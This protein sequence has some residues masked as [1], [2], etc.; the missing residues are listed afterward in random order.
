MTSAEPPGFNALIAL[1]YEAAL[2]SR[3]WTDF[4]T[5]L[6]VKLNSPVGSIWANDFGTREVQTNL[7]SASYGFD[8]SYLSSFDAYYGSKNVWLD[9]PRLHVEGRSV[10]DAM[11]YPPS[12]LKSTEYWTDWLRPQDL[13]HTAAV[14]I[15]NRNN[16]SVN[17]TVLRSEKCGFYTP[18]EMALVASLVPHMQTGFAM[19]R[20]LHRL[21]TLS[22]ASAHVLEA[23]PLGIVLLDENA[24]VLFAN[25]LARTLTRSNKLIRLSTAAGISCVRASD[26][27]IFQKL[28]R[29]AA[30]TGVSGSGSAGGALKVCGLDGEQLHVVVTPFPSWSTPFGTSASTA[31]FLNDPKTALRSLAQSLRMIYGMSPTEAR[32]TEAL[33]SGLSPKEYAHDVGVSMNTVRTQIKASAAKVGATRQ[34]DLVRLVLTGPAVL[35]F[36]S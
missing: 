18:Q 28:V 4:L 34:S 7:G 8:S 35:R 22:R 32:L 25:E 14:I 1:I 26:D 17:L 33:I 36:G 24:E 23:V 27:A 3:K 2:D 16:R 9:D 13:F 20:K 29:E 5:A 12:R 6:A 15:Q 11:L 31:V 21:E 19:L 30:R 10:T